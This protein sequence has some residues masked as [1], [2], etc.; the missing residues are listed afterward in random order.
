MNKDL[1]WFAADLVRGDRDG[2]GRNLPPG[3]R[4]EVFE[5]LGD[6]AQVRDG[7]ARRLARLNLRTS[8]S[9]SDPW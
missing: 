5:K 2:E 7:A 9:M 3:E 1:E 8:Y 6:P 4:L